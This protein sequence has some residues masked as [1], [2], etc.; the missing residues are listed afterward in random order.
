MKKTTKRVISLMAVLAMAA[1][2]SIVAFAADDDKDGI[3]A[4][5]DK[6]DTTTIVL[7]FNK[8]M[9]DGMYYV[10]IPQKVELKFDITDKLWKADDQI[11]ALY[12]DI[13]IP[14]DKT[15][16]VGIGDSATS[17][18]TEV[19]LTGA[20]NSSITLSCSVTMDNA[21]EI[22]G[23]RESTD[24]TEKTETVHFATTQKLTSAQN[25]EG[26]VNFTLAVENTETT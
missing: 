14:S 26:S 17:T 23:D 18:E 24:E 11:S 8:E 5:P 22:A 12:E 25:Y 2:T 1:S 6:H 9:P 4:A 3:I 21:F 10:T 15:L 7:D 13:L 20:T 19:T 16:K